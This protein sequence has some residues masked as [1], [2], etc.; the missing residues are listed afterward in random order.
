VKRKDVERWTGPK[1]ATARENSK[2]LE[3]SFLPEEDV[4]GCAP[5]PHFTLS[6]GD[7]ISDRT[8]EARE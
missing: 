3:K 8:A 2:G 5:L 7:A 6:G 1:Q 4:S